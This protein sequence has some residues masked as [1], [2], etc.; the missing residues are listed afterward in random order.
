MH[1]LYKKAYLVAVSFTSR[2]R[3]SYYEV[4]FCIFCIF[5]TTQDAS[6]LQKRCFAPLSAERYMKKVAEYGNRGNG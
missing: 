5:L 4:G 1:N 2:F 3:N 6:S